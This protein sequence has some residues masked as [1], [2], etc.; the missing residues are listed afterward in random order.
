MARRG[1]CSGLWPCIASN[2]VGAQRISAPAF[3]FKVLEKLCERVFGAVKV[4]AKVAELADIFAAFEQLAPQVKDS[5]QFQLRHKLARKSAAKDEGEEKQEKHEKQNK[6][7]EHVGEEDGYFHIAPPLSIE[8]FQ[9]VCEEASELCALVLAPFGYMRDL[10]P[11][12]PLTLL[13]RLED[14]SMPL[15]AALA[16]STAGGSRAREAGTA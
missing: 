14:A 1:R 16:L 13:R 6:R 4:D 5:F 3:L 7:E 11:I 15:P 12:N 2:V 9:R 10:F 8:K